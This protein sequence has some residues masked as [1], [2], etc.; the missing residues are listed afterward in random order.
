[1]QMRLL[2]LQC[3]VYYTLGGKTRLECA[4]K[5]NRRNASVSGTSIYSQ[6]VSQRVKKLYSSD[7][8]VEE[9]STSWLIVG[10]GKTHSK[11]D[12]EMIATM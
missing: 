11:A 1:M 8:L 4:C 9:A 2:L 3:N 5:R 6:C 7:T 12:G 10:M